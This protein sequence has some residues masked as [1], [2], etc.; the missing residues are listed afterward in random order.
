MT[1]DATSDRK[2]TMMMEKNC[3]GTKHRALGEANMWVFICLVLF[4]FS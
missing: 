2:T 4:K 3:R 1:A